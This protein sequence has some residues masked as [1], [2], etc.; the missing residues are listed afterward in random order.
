LQLG[1]KNKKTK[2][3]NGMNIFAQTRQCQSHIS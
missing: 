3:D 1:T 2:N